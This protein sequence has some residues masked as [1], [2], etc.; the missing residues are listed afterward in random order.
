MFKQ[1]GKLPSEV[2]RQDPV[3]LFKLLNMLEEPEEE[4]EIP[5]GLK[6]LYGY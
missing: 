3:L 2:A 6:F 4:P 1:H 5:E